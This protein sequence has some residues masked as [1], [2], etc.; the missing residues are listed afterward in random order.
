[1]IVIRTMDCKKCGISIKYNAESNV[2]FVDAYRAYKE[3]CTCK[4]E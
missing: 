2:D 1:M 4:E 3:R